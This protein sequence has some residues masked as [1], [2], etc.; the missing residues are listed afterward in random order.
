MNVILVGRVFENAFLPERILCRN[1]NRFSY[2]RFFTKMEIFFATEIR[3]CSEMCVNNATNCGV[4]GPGEY[5]F[6]LPI[7]T[8]KS[9]LNFF[10]ISSYGYFQNRLLWCDKFEILWIFLQPRDFKIVSTS[11]LWI[12][13]KTFFIVYYYFL[14]NLLFL[15]SSSMTWSIFAAANDKLI[16]GKNFETKIE[17]DWDREFLGKQMDDAEDEEVKCFRSAGIESSLEKTAQKTPKKLLQKS[18]CLANH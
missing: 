14:F 12:V 9:F 8:P 15:P 16:S 17:Q 6:K 18:G 5:R 7:M 4:T 1:I 10:K 13:S 11:I 3:R 2:H